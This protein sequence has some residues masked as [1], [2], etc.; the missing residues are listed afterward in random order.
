ML[1]IMPQHVQRSFSLRYMR[2]IC[3][4]KNLVLLTCL[5]LIGILPKFTERLY[6]GQEWVYYFGVPKRYGNYHYIGELLKA[7]K[8]IDIAFI[9]SSNF[10]TSIIPARIEESIVRLTGKS[11]VIENLSVSWY[12]TESVYLRVSDVQKYLKPKI[13]ITDEA[14]ALNWP[15]ELTRYMVRASI[16]SISGLSP[17]ERL[18]LYSISALAAPRQLWFYIKYNRQDTK[19]TN[20]AYVLTSEYKKQRGFVKEELGWLSHYNKN[21]DERLPYIDYSALFKSSQMKNKQCWADM[22]AGEI[23]QEL[24]W[25]YTS[26][27]TAFLKAASEFVKSNDSSFLVFAMPTH[28]KEGEYRDFYVERPLFNKELK[29]WS[30]VGFP[31]S[32]IFD[33]ST[34]LIFYSNESHLNYTG[35]RLFSECVANFLSQMSYE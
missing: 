22:S 6:L 29:S 24:G 11:P 34:Q 21:R 30:T 17:L 35:A 5:L 27:Q 28:F 12:G 3:N 25:T 32:Q 14:E 13:I 26:Y 18:T 2:K 1:M 15:H 10:Q 9:G 31:M 20:D 33:K 16:A 19:L 7:G 8:P 23:R 4:R